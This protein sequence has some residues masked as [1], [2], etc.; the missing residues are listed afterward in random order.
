MKGVEQVGGGP[1]LVSNAVTGFLGQRIDFRGRPLNGD[2][3][4]TIALD[5]VAI[6]GNPYPSAL[7]M[8]KFLEDNTILHLLYH[9][10]IQ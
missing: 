1:N 4:M 8:K 3:S 7:D 5:D 6:I 2:I 10:L 9:K